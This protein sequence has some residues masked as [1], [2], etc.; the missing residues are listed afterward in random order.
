MKNEICINGI[1]YEFKFGIGFMREINREVRAAVPGVEG[2]VKRDLGLKYRISEIFD[3]DIDALVHV[4]EVANKTCE[5]RI[6][7]AAL[8][9]YIEDPGTDIDALFET[10]KGFFATANCC[11]TA[12]A[13]VE[14][15]AKKQK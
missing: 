11:K 10:V 8:E 2:N 9:E 5:P 14:K 13:A 7:R 3:G 6:P 12:Y 4:L 1:N 15:E